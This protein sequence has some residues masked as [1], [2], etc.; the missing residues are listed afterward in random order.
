ME[1]TLL[2]IVLAPLAA[3]I[4]AGFFGRQIGRAATHSITI[5]GA[6]SSSGRPMNGALPLTIRVK[7]APKAPARRGLRYPAQPP[8]RR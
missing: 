4:I 7:R 8:W 2:I 5:A 3:S 1:Q 6:N